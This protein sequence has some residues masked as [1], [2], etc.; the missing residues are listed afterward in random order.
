MN[1]MSLCWSAEVLNTQ[2]GDACR[3]ECSANNCPLTSEPSVCYDIFISQIF[4]GLERSGGSHVAVTT[5]RNP[6]VLFSPL[7][8]L[9]CCVRVVSTLIVFSLITEAFCHVLSVVSMDIVFLICTLYIYILFSFDSTVQFWALATSMKLSISF[10][11]LDL[12][13]SAGLLWR[14]I[15]SSQGLC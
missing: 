2:R 11:L 13:Q 3:S 5:M 4:L 14:V 10:R 8:F 12:G 9:C 6:S 7:I 1:K 15:S